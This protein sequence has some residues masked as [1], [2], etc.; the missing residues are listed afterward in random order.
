MFIG[1]HTA[2]HRFLDELVDEEVRREISGSRKQLM[3]DLGVRVNLISAP[4]GRYTRESIEAAR[5][6]G[7]RGF[8]CSTPD[9]NDCSRDRFVWTRVVV[10][11]K[12]SL[13]NFRKIINADSGIYARLRLKNKVRACA[14]K[15]LGNRLYQI[16]HSALT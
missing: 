1:S 7:Y 15:I 13:K 16:L 3:E 10:T 2:S 9:V 11:S 14:K 12:T 8:A 5:E 4:G 6:F